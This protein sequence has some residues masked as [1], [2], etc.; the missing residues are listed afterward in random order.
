MQYIDINTWL[1]DDILLKA[2]KMN[3]ANSIECRMPFLD[4]KVIEL[5][6]EIPTKFKLENNDTKYVFRKVAQK[7][8]KNEVSQKE[9]LGFP[10]PICKWLK[11]ESIYK[12]VRETFINNNLL[13]QKYILKLLDNHYYKNVDNSR[14]IWT[15][16]SFLIWYNVYFNEKA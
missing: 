4:E 3:M 14:K 2:D 8:L 9:K 10:V 1:V 6:S 11:N 15:I 7:N 5:A 12:M 13:N 16:Y